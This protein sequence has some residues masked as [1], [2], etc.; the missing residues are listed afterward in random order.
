ML[1]SLRGASATGT[2]PGTDHAACTAAKNKA[3]EALRAQ[4]PQNLRGLHFVNQTL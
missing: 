3:R 2:A 4:V 1:K